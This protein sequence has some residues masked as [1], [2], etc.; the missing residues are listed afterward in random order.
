M[1]ASQRGGT[2]KAISD[3]TNRAQRDRPA[4]LVHSIQHTTRPLA[5]NW[6]HSDPHASLHVQYRT[7]T[8]P[9]ASPET[10]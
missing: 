1:R 3:S 9:R 7:S 10:V 5:D 6:Q 8:A 2:E 4:Q